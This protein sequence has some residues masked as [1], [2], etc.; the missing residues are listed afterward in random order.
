MSREGGEGEEKRE[1]DE[2][3][4]AFCTHSSVVML[5]LW[6]SAVAM[7]VAPSSPMLL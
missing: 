2:K 7:A 3:E 5:L 4:K 1:R 6:W